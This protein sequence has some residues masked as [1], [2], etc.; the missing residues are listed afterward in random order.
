MRPD[1]ERIHTRYPL[2][3]STPDYEDKLSLH[4]LSFF[5]TNFRLNDLSPTEN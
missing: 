3:A 5:W 4:P 1:E 2:H